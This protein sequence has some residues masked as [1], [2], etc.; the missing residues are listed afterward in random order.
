VVVKHGWKL[1]AISNNFFKTTLNL[2]PFDI[3]ILGRLGPVYITQSVDPNSEQTSGV[4][5]S[6][7]GKKTLSPHST[8]AI[9]KNLSI[10]LHLYK[11]N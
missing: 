1:V 7:S 9:V 5:Q 4:E 8:H 6:P 11:N 3:P 2:S 10:S